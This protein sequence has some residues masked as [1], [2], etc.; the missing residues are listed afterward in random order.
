MGP[1]TGFKVLE[2]AAIGPAPFCGMMLADLGA[3]IIRIDRKGS[4]PKH[5]NNPVNRGRRSLALDLK[6]PGAA[7]VVLRLVEQA[8]VLIEGFRPGVM[9][10]LG[11]GPDTC[12]ERRPTLIYGRMTG[13]GQTGPLAQAAG[14]D[15]NYIALTGVLHSLAVN[16]SVPVP[17][18]NLVG[19]YGGGGMLLTTGVLAALLERG[20]SGKGQVV[21][22]AMTDGSASLMSL[23]YGLKAAGA[24]RGQPGTNLLDGGAHFYGCYQCADGLFISIG[25]IEPQFYAELLQR[26]NI[27]DDTFQQQMNPDQWPGLKIKLKTIFASRTRAQWCQL[28]EGTDVCFAPVLSLDEAPEHPHNKAR[29][30]FTKFNGVVQPSPAPRFSRTPGKLHHPP[31]D[32]GQHSMDI[33]TEHGFSVDDIR[34]LQETGMI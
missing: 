34:K 33:L 30:S 3:E 4:K 21:D 9:E 27:T 29:G 12:L 15:I 26:C 23:F 8:D 10:R 14:H 20:R 11:L 25:P 18:L 5:D 17:P 31:P 2:M 6:Q 16:N 13:W 22:A 1:L 19:D 7:E 24:W 28:L 32:Y